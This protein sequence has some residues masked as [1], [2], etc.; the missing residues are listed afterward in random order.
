METQKNIILKL[1]INLIIL[2]DCIKPKN[3]IFTTYHVQSNGSYILNKIFLIEDH[4]DKYKFVF[5]TP[6]SGRQSKM[7]VD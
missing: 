5:S 6:N 2:Y 3:L 7:K 1:N 4:I